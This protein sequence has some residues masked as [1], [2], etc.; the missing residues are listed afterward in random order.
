MVMANGAPTRSHFPTLCQQG[1]G[2]R[3]F[4][5]TGVGVGVDGRPPRLCA[6]P[7]VFCALHRLQNETAAREVLE[8]IQSYFKSQPFDFRGAQIISGQEEGVYGWITANYIMGNFL[9]VRGKK[10]MVSDLSIDPV[11]V[12]DSGGG[13]NT[14][15]N[16]RGRA[17]TSWTVLLIR[18]KSGEDLN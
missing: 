12:G 1:P 2:R 5:T 15:D 9:E 3:C 10:R 18:K 13:G 16:I 8:S 7:L 14:A 6:Q 4:L 11:P 17:L